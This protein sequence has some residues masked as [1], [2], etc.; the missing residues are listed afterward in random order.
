MGKKPSYLWALLV[1]ILFPVVQYVLS[2]PQTGGSAGT[3]PA[4]MDYLVFFLAG[5]FIGAALIYL[6]RRSE[7]PGAS[8]AVIIAFVVGLPFA[9]FGLILGRLAG[10][11]GA[12][13]LSI[14]PG[15]F[16]TLMGYLIGRMI[17]RRK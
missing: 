13:M 6:L 15:V 4:L 12:F 16:F 8:R 9:L 7:T 1:G 17:S 5:T 11:I 2:L 14:S 3:P 10:P